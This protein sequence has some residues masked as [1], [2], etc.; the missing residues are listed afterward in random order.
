MREELELCLD[1]QEVEVS[2]KS[3]DNNQNTFLTESFSILNPKKTLTERSSNIEKSLDQPHYDR[4]IIDRNKEL[5]GKLGGV[6]TK[7]EE[8]R[9]EFL[10]SLDIDIDT[11]LLDN[12]DL[13]VEDHDDRV[14]DI[15]NYGGVECSSRL[16]DINN[17]IELIVFLMIIVLVVR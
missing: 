6:L 7:L 17:K 12:R 14:G 3:N 15:L 11:N 13:L 16:Q 2:K 8:E 1:Q 4:H 10:L 5:A 9:I